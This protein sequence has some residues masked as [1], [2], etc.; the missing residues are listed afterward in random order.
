MKAPVAGRVEAL[1]VAE[2]DAVEAGAALA[3]IEPAVVS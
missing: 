2:G 1:M 3:R